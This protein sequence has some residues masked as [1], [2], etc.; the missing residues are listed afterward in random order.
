[1]A[2]AAF[3]AGCF[4]GVQH[5]FDQV[6]GVKNT[7]AGYM[8]GATKNPSYKEVCAD[9]TGHAETVHIDFDEKIVSY[10]GLLDIFW[11]IHNPTQK[12]RQG[13]DVGTQYR[14]VVFYYTDEQKRISEE[15]RKKQEL[16][17]RFKKSIATEI[18]AASEFYP[19]EEYHQHYFGKNGVTGCPI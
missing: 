9:K 11:K 18:V 10:E 12:N 4:W 3:A 7:V 15:S 1:M 2:Q 13:P 16:S 8:G 14:S 6:E 17:G 5:E 19:A